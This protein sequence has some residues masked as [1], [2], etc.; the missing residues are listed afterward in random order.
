MVKGKKLWVVGGSAG[1]GA[2]CARLF[3]E[4]GADVAVSGR[5]VAR[6]EQMAESMGEVGSG[7]LVLTRAD[8][9]DDDSV[10][11]AARSV[12]QGLD[13]LDGVVISGGAPA[14]GGVFEL[15]DSDWWEG[16]NQKLM[17]QI[18]VVRAVLPYFLGQQ[19]GRIVHLVGTHGLQPQYY[20]LAAGV[21]NAGL[22]NF[23]K[24][25]ARY[26]ASR[27]VLVNAVNPG[28]VRTARMERLA[29]GKAQQ[30]GIR[31]EDAVR[32]LAEEVALGRFAEPA[33]VAGLVGWLLSDEATYCTGAYFNV[34]GGQIYGL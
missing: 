12:I 14:P 33:E 34:D 31:P 22:L 7:T 23:V 4:R 19:S 15:T 2:E 10:R 25:V 5:N 30:D 3:I 27:N 1:I 17:G 11:E 32:Q 28:P 13:G 18:R 8:L 29:A 20:A 9:A 24:A 16:L 26:A 6:L 21:I